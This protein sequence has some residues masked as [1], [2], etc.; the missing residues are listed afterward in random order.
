[1]TPR[2]P[3]G[4]ARCVDISRPVPDGS[5]GAETG[6]RSAK[7]PSTGRS[8][9]GHPRPGGADPG[10]GGAAPGS[11][12]RRGPPAAGGSRPGL[13][14]AQ[15][16]GRRGRRR[17]PGLELVV[18]AGRDREDH[19]PRPRRHPPPRHG[20]VVFGV[21]PNAAAAQV[22][23]TETGMPPTPWTSCSTNTPTRPA[24]R[25]RFDLPP[26][27]RWWSTRP[28]GLHPKL[29][30]LACPRQQRWRVVLVGDPR[31]FSAVGRGGMFGHLVD[32]YGA[33]ELDQVHRFTHHWER[34]ASLRLRQGDPTV[35]TEYDPE[36]ASTAAPSPTWRPRSSTPGGRPRARRDRGAD[37]QQQRHRR[38]AQPLAQQARITAG[39]LDPKAP[40][41]ARRA[42]GAGGR[43]GG[44]P[45]QR[46]HPP[47]RPGSHGQE[48]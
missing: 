40:A 34:E 39:E 24:T 6:D 16:S 1:M 44:H 47:H 41:S 4:R 33:V 8:P 28:D 11:G 43:R 20:R 15:A 25:P 19:R 37:G 5:P 29:A 13:D 7:P 21:A 32:T 36:A 9:P 31:Q 38:P 35:L 45:P 17:R 3:G 22:L 42:G 27:R 14:R 46:P 18:G 26:G 23:A 10:V 12:Q 2:R 48:P 30:E